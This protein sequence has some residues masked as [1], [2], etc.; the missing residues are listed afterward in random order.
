MKFILGVLA[1][2]V[3]SNAAHADSYSCAKMVYK[4]GWLRK[5]EYLGNTWGA[6]TKKSGIL[7]STAGSTVEKITSSVDP[8]VTTGNG[9]SSIQYVSSWGECAMVEMMITKQIREEYIDQNMSE[10]KR[11]VA[12]GQ[13]YHVD[14]LAMISGCD[15]QNASE[16]SRALQRNTGELYD[17]N[18]GAAFASQLN[19]IVLSN[20]S[21]RTTCA[22]L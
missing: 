16:W 20:S 18:S 12:M 15:L 2:L 4:D 3:L 22:V 10:I 8:G 14:A 11:Q 7:S 6:N 19:A 1:G 9:M 13:G 17:L 5:Y 21:L